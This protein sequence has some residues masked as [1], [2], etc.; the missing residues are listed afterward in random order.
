MSPALA[1]LGLSIAG[2]W[3]AASLA[4][5]ASGIIMIFFPGDALTNSDNVLGGV[6]LLGAGLIS[7]GLMQITI[8]PLLGL[9]PP[10]PIKAKSIIPADQ[11]KRWTNAGELA[12]FEN[13]VPTEMRLRTNRVTIVRDGDQAYALAG[14]CPHARLP[15]AGFPGSPVKPEPIRDECVTCPFHGARFELETGRVVRQPFSSE[16]NAAHPFL[17]RFQEK[18][19]FFNQRAEN[20]QT[21]PCEVDDG[22][23]MVKL[24]R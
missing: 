8:S 14:L 12:E 15:F 7:G 4:L 1:F 22:N 21:Y 6:F 24:P 10:L 19:L 9:D 13:G 5:I 20:V 3:G 16:F 11:L 2:T 18:L 23:V 17:G